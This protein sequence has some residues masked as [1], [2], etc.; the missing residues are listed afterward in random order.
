MGFSQMFYRREV[1][2]HGHGSLASFVT[3]L[4]AACD[5][6]AEDDPIPWLRMG[7]AHPRLHAIDRDSVPIMES[8][9]QEPH[10]EKHPRTRAALPGEGPH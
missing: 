1:Q 8:A 10:R 5:L 7:N 4:G 6:V 9:S 2:D 3:R